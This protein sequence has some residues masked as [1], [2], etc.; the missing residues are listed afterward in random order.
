MPDFDL[1][2]VVTLSW[3]P[4][5]EAV[6]VTWHGGGATAAEFDA[7]LEAELESMRRHTSARLLADCRHQRPL[8]IEAQDRADSSWLP[9]AVGFGLRRFAV[10]LPR[11]REAAVNLMDHLG[12]VNRTEIEVQF[13]ETVDQ[14]S[15]WLKTKTRSTAG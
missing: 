5:L 11:D 10:V 8:D 15:S 14:A 13:F 2:G 7:L 1:P 6:T 3:E 4:A 9:Q 12:R